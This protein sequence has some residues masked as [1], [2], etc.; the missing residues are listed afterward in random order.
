MS[1]VARPGPQQEER[2]AR[3][4]AGAMPASE[5][6]AFEREALADDA[7]AEALYSEESLEAQIGRAHV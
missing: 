5:R 2:L 4:R 7:L 6:A 1:G 3:Y